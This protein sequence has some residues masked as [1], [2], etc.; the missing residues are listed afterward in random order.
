[1]SAVCSLP[2]Q[3]FRRPEHFISMLCLPET[4]SRKTGTV[5]AIHKILNSVDRTSITH[6]THVTRFTSVKGIFW[7]LLKYVFSKHRP[8]GPMLS[9][10]QFVHMCVCLSVCSLLRYRLNVFLP[11]TSQSRMSKYFRDSESLGKSNG[12]KWSQI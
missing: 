11:P 3:M 7:R 4:Q 10:S 12:T 1:M 9:I 2:M 5:S 6:K 8:S